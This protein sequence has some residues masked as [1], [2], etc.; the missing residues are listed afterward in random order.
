MDKCQPER[1]FKTAYSISLEIR[2]AK[3]PAE[4]EIE[5][6][7]FGKNSIL[8]SLEKSGKLRNAVDQPSSKIKSKS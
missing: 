7:L 8:E 2:I 5:K 3:Q 6:P 1:S 4:R